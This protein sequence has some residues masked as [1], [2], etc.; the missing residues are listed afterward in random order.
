MWHFREVTRIPA[1]FSPGQL[2]QPTLFSATARGRSA[3]LPCGCQFPGAPLGRAAGPARR[4]CCCTAASGAAYD[5]SHC[6][7]LAS[8]LATAGYAVCV[9]EY[10]RTGQ[11][12]GGWPGTFDDVAAAVDSLP[13]MAAE[14]AAGRGGQATVLLAGHSARGPPG[15]VGG[16]TE[17]APRRI[18]VAPRG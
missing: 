5:R 3:K 14:A 9:P 13:R 18:A 4:W 1:R 17:P 10:R 2:R 12:G 11:A 16:G 6:G 7:P 15:F 8:A